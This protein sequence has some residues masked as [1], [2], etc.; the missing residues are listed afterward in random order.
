VYAA[1]LTTS[2]MKAERDYRYLGTELDGP[3]RQNHPLIF[4]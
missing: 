3:S 4:Y 1:A 2:L